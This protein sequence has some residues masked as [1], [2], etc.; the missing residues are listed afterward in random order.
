MFFLAT[1]MIAVWVLITGYILYMSQ[2][3]RQL[4]GEV[5]TL[6][7]MAAARGRTRR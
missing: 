2:R 3:Q 4:E 5:R 1:A 7:E 6:E